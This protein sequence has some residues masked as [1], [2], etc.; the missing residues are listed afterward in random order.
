MSGVHNCVGEFIEAA[1]VP[2]VTALLESH[3]A[4][5]T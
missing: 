4:R 3:G 2:L 5:R 1:R